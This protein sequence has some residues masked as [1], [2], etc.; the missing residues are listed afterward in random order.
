MYI[1]SGALDSMCNDLM[2]TFH[3]ALHRA[4]FLFLACNMLRPQTR[5]GNRISN[6]VAY[7]S[8]L[9][10]LAATSPPSGWP[11]PRDPFM[12]AES[13]CPLRLEADRRR[14]VEALPLPF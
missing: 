13:L 4:S 10:L 1:W 5:V 8:Q 12:D 9:N 3:R 6:R 14:L 2:Y 7:T 11:N